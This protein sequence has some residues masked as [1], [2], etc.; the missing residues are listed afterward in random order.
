MK[1]NLA[2]RVTLNKVKNYSDFQK[3]RKYDVFEHFEE[4]VTEE[5][6][7]TLVS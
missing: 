6:P 3:I 5:Y 2:R 1:E 7:F 4:E